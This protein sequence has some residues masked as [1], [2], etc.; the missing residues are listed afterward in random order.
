MIFGSRYSAFY[1][2]LFDTVKEFPGTPHLMH[3]GNF[4]GSPHYIHGNILFCVHNN[5]VS[6]AHHLRKCHCPCASN[7]IGLRYI[8]LRYHPGSRRR[9]IRGLQYHSS[10]L[11]CSRNESAHAHIIRIS[12]GIH[13]IHHIIVN[14]EKPSWPYNSHPR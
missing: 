5:R 13:L 3:P 9:R 11:R 4:G 12:I 8:P 1:I 7:V 2:T 10:H 14:L 6:P